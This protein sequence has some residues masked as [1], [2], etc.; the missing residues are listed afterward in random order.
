MVTCRIAK[1]DGLIASPARTKNLYSPIAFVAVGT[2]EMKPLLESVK[3]S[4]SDPLSRDQTKAFGRQ[5]ADNEK[6]ENRP[7]IP[8]PRSPL[9]TLTVVVP[10][11]ICKPVT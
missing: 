3:P 7:M 11:P 6:K 1:F 4:G 5:H 2:P 10:P 8:M 9:L